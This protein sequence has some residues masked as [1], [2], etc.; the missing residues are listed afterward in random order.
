MKTFLHAQVL[1]GG[2]SFCMQ[3]KLV[4]CEDFWFS[5]LYFSELKPQLFSSSLCEQ[6]TLKGFYFFKSAHNFIVS[7]SDWLHYL[8][9]V[10]LQFCLVICVSAFP[11]E[12]GLKRP[13]PELEELLFRSADC[14]NTSIVAFAILSN[15]LFISATD[16]EPYSK[17]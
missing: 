11:R 7:N 12:F 16:P 15:K 4:L 10:F 13:I 2:N 6:T 14:W 9:N 17:T 3:K 1:F 8:R 5:T